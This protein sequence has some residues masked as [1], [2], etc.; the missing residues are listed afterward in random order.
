MQASDDDEKSVNANSKLQKIIIIISSVVLLT[1]IIVINMESILLSFEYPTNYIKIT[2]TKYDPYRDT[3]IRTYSPNNEINSFKTNIATSY[4]AK[5]EN[6]IYLA[7]INGVIQIN[8]DNLEETNT[9]NYEFKS[10]TYGDAYDISFSDD[11]NVY[12]ALID[13]YNESFLCKTDSKLKNDNCILV[14]NLLIES[15]NIANNKLYVIGSKNIDSDEGKLYILD[16]DLNL[17][18]EHN[19]GE[20]YG[21]YYYA[22]DNLILSTGDDGLYVKDFEGNIDNYDNYEYNHYDETNYTI[23]IQKYS[24]S[25]Y[26]AKNNKLIMINNYDFAN[27]IEL[28]TYEKYG[29]F[30][31]NKFYFYQD[32]NTNK[33]NEYDIKTNTL[34]TH[35][36]N[37]S[38]DD[39]NFFFFQDGQEK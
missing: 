2:T 31:D 38:T 14:H 37:R 22:E 19:L 35:D 36:I 7:G 30:S 4:V 21:N 28:Y 39:N 24:D 6:N 29:Y 9:F 16:L 13:N 18:S 1:T 26:I 32:E 11:N 17:L 27:P 8:G 33:I 3:E 5:R 15:V 12:F 20:N 34:T 10:G 23:D 25:F